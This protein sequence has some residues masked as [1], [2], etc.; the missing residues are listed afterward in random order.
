[1]KELEEKKFLAEYDVS[2][3]FRPS[4]TVDTIVFTIQEKEQENYRKLPEKTLQVMLIKRKNHPFKDKWCFPGTFVKEQENL[5]NAIVRVL[6]EKA[7]IENLYLEQLYTWGDPKRDPR[8]RIISTSYMGLLND[9]KINNNK[10]NEIEWFSIKTNL[11]GTKNEKKES[12]SKKIEEIELILESHNVI[13]KNRLRVVKENIQN[14]LVIYTEIL[15]S[16][17]AFDH[18]KFL[19]YAIERLKN[20]VEYTAVIFNLMPELFTLTNLQHV[21]EILLDKKLLKAN[22]RRK[23][24]KMVIETELYDETAGFRPSKLYKFNKDWK[25]ELF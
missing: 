18:A 23:I 21:Y 20:K 12:G 2:K 4:V 9:K 5:E 17:L 19:I 15:E 22:F 7:N 3:F 14:N 10:A 8:T 1:M 25:P 16:D 24:S 6:K 11:L 13:L